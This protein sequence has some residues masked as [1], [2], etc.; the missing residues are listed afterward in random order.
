VEDDFGLQ[1]DEDLPALGSASENLKISREEWSANNRAL[2]VHVAGIAGKRYELRAYGAKIA[3]LD[4]AELKQ[5]S[6]GGQ[7]IEIAFPSAD[8]PKRFAEQEVTIHF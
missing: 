5:L 6:S 8:V 1:V 7:T 2:K 3:S 4:G